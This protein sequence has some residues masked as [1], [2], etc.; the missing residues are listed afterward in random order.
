MKMGLLKPAQT[1]KVSVYFSKIKE[2]INSLKEIRE[3][4][5]RLCLKNSLISTTT[6]CQKNWNFYYKLE[7]TDYTNKADQNQN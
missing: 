2:Q 7:I 5:L 6:G 3:K 4:K 1:L